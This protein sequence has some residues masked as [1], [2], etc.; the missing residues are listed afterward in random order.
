M[1]HLWAMAQFVLQPEVD[2]SASG[3]RAAH[4]QETK[5]SIVAKK[6]MLPVEHQEHCL[7]DAVLC[8]QP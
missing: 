2:K 5:V 8:S 1:K 6:C 4:M 3:R 7:A